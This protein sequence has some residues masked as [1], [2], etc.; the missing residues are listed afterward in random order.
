[1]NVDAVL[2]DGEILEFEFDGKLALF[3]LEGGGAGVLT[4]AGLE[5]NDDFILGFSK[6][7]NSEETKRKCGDRVAHK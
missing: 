5:G 7:W 4:G 6:G 3:L 2:A 1:V